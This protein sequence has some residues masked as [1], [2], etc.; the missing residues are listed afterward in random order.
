MNL[1]LHTFHTYGLETSQVIKMFSNCK[2]FSIRNGAFCLFKFPVFT[3][4][5][6]R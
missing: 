4:N 6:L 5:Y 3:W 2:Q 1:F